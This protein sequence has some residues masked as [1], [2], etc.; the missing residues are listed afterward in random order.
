MDFA[1]G[2][3]RSNPCSRMKYFTDFR[4]EISSLN[5]LR[6]LASKEN[7]NSYLE[8]QIKETEN[9]I[10]SDP[11]AFTRL[12][13]L[14]SIRKHTSSAPW[15]HEHIYLKQFRIPQIVLFD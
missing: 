1:V 2:S 14:N 6:E 3:R 5:R 11:E 13:F 8:L 10:N 9:S 7:L 15:S 12:V 4:R